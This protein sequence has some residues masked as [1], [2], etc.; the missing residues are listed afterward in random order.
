VFRRI[1]YL[2]SD[3]GHVLRTHLATRRAALA[4]GGLVVLAGLA[5][6]IYVLVEELAEDEPPPP[7]AAPEAVVKKVEADDEKA[8]DL[9]FPAFA[10]RN[11][12]RVSG[13]DPVADAAAV[14]LS[15][16]PST[17]GLEG[18]D[19]VSIAD[20][21]DWAGAV[22]AASLFAEPVSAPLLFSD[23][24]TLPELTQSALGALNPRGSAETN[25][26]QAFVIGSAVEPQGLRSTAAEGQTPAE[27]AASV[28]KLREKLTGEKPEHI[29]VTGSDEPAFAMPAAGW[30][31]RSGDP[32]LYAQRDSIPKPTLEVLEDYEDVPV[33]VL[34]PDAAV[35]PKA[36][37]E[38]EK[39]VGDVT[40]ISGKDPVSNSIE[41]ARFSDG[42]FGWNINDPGHGFVLLNA[43]RPSDAGAAAPLSASGSWGPAL[44][45]DSADELP[46]PLRGY[47]LD[48][49][50][51]YQ[52]DPTRAVYNHVWIIGDESAISVPFQAQVDELAELVEVGTGTG[53]D[54]LGP[55][56]GAQK[57][58]GAPKADDNSAGGG[59][60]SDD[61]GGGGSASDNS[62]GSDAASRDSGGAGDQR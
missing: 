45:T 30:A 35:S 58:G 56:P 34:G 52:E 10:T 28:A 29:L 59:G 27:V 36:V 55:P 7:A 15:T 4:L 33:Y 54:V 61:S 24:D 32:V 13:A 46:G 12:T 17:G 16:Y 1:R 44:V 50:P 22:A 42:S 57:D 37:D 47:L 2:L 41:F 49:K 23:G 48:L 3:L 62:A 31:A 38:L 20:A 9:G 19:A 60:A 8:E 21:D 26:D 25:D 51:G 18:P 14:A 5:V 39:A 11:T 40:R 6:G 43:D 53:A